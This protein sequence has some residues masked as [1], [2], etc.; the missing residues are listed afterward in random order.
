MFNMRSQ[1]LFLI[2]DKKLFPIKNKTI[3]PNSATLHSQLYNRDTV[4][5][6]FSLIVEIRFMNKI[7]S[8]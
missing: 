2:D 4:T 3:K 6:I 1:T 5:H 8:I 7:Q